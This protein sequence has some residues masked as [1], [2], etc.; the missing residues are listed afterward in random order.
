MEHKI[1]PLD[2]VSLLQAIP[3]LG[4][5]ADQVGTVVEVFG[6]ED[7]EVEFVDKQWRTSEKPVL[8]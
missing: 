3:A 8:L 1:Q 2:T 6:E 4:L 7:G 5:K